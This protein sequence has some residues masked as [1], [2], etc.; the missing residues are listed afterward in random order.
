[1]N[2]GDSLSVSFCEGAEPV[3][4]GVQ[5]V[6]YAEAGD[7]IGLAHGE[8]IKLFAL[9]YNLEAKGNEIFD[10][11][12][13]NEWS[14]GWLWRSPSCIYKRVSVMLYQGDIYHSLSPPCTHLQTN[15][16]RQARCVCFPPLPLG[17]VVFRE[18]F[19]AET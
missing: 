10:E 18:Q 15:F 4:N 5:I 11:I 8:A 9:F 19:S 14:T 1:M 6:S 12:E 3:L 17:G 16:G 2:F 7:T 13:V